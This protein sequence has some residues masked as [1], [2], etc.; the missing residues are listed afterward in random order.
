[1]KT[2]GSRPSNLSYWSCQSAGNFQS[3]LL[4]N[5]VM[6]TLLKKQTLPGSDSPWSAYDLSFIQDGTLNPT[7]E[8]V[9]VDSQ[10]LL[11]FCPEELPRPQ[12]LSRRQA[13][14]QALTSAWR[15]EG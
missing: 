4:V 14:G 6:K 8:A 2:N 9:L 11:E 10:E 7:Q 5:G 3:L 15:G 12:L 1:M 13:R